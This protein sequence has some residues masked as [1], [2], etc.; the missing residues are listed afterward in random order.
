MKPFAAR[1]NGM[2]MTGAQPIS[3]RNR[4]RH[5]R[6]SS[7]KQPRPAK[8]KL[9]KKMPEPVAPFPAHGHVC[10]NCGYEVINN[11][12]SNC[13]QSTATH[14]LSIGHFVVHDLIHSIWH[15]DRGIFF[16]LKE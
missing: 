6:S 5:T 3:V 10:L 8:V 12:C 4:F 16:T 14:R 2:R 1:R 15:V 13:G 11:F 9:A 7:M